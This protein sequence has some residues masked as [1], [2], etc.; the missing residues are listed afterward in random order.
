MVCR[1]AAALRKDARHHLLDV[2][3]KRKLG[4]VSGSESI[5]EHSRALATDNINHLMNDTSSESNNH[6]S[7]RLCVE[8]SSSDFSSSSSSSSR[9]LERSI[10][11]LDP[12]AGVSV[13]EFFSGIGLD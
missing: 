11:D 3:A 9:S 5:A 1:C 6:S 12:I 8:L 13:F 2:S 4:L 10:K 7:K